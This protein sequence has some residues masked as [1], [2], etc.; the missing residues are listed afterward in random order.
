MANASA[1]VPGASADQVAVDR[2]RGAE[3]LV[4]EVGTDVGAHR[5]QERVGADHAHHPQIDGAARGRVEELHDV[6]HVD[7]D[8]SGGPPPACRK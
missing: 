3:P 1:S 6:A 4:H 7:A 2:G 5:E 8:P